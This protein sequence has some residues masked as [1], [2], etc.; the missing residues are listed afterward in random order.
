MDI[1]K[2]RQKLEKKKRINRTLIGIYWTRKIGNI[3]KLYK[4]L[5][6]SLKSII[7]YKIVGLSISYNLQKRNL[8]YLK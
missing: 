1:L 8:K 5:F 7:F 2:F 6:F 4:K 3:F